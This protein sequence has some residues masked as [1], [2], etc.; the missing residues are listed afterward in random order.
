MKTVANMMVTDLLSRP[1]C[2][3]DTNGFRIFLNSN[4]TYV[5]GAIAFYGCIERYVSNFFVNLLTPAS[6][7]VDVGANVGWYTM[8]AAKKAKSVYSFEPEPYSYSLLQKSVKWNRVS[9]VS[10]F[11]YAIGDRNEPGELA[12]SD[13]SNKGGHSLVNMVGRT[14]IP[15]AI[16]RLD[17]VLSN[18]EP[19]D[20]LKVDAEGYEPNVLE[21]ASGLTV[22]NIIMEWNPNVWSKTAR[23][24][25]IKRYEVF[26][27]GK[28]ILRYKQ[29][30]DTTLPAIWLVPRT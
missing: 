2:Y 14:K 15:V 12:I 30:P 25:L 28:K 17:S 26:I 20:L 1:D 16:W 11:N 7:V 3:K 21:G 13:S 18:A 19:I 23:D 4:D 8:L 29:I 10:L 22:K 27:I 6:I 24:L 9:N 5:S